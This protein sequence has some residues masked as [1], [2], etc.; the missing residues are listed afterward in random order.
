[1]RIAR[2]E[3]MKNIIKVPNTSQASD[4][5]QNKEISQT[6]NTPK[7]SEASEGM[8][9]ENQAIKVEEKRTKKSNTAKKIWNSIQAKL[10]IKK[11][12]VN[13]AREAEYLP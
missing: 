12:K 2:A 10:G 4:T 3:N 5:P 11:E 9:L 1:M 13:A 7:N 6:S 8:L